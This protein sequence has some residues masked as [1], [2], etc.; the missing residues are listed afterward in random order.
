MYGLNIVTLIIKDES[1][2]IIKFTTSQKVNSQS[3]DDVSITKIF[4]TK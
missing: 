2:N 4:Q 3:I 1:D